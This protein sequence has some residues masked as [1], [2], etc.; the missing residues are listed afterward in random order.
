MSVK[1]VLTFK[2]DWMTFNILTETDFFRQI[3]NN[4]CNGLQTAYNGFI[5]QVIELCSHVAESPHSLIALL[6][7]ETELQHHQVSGD[8]AALVYVRKALT[9][10]EKIHKYLSTAPISAFPLSQPQVR[11]EIK[12]SVIYQWTR[13]QVELV[14]IIYGLAEMECFN[15]GEVQINELASYI[16]KLFGVEIKDCYH[17]YID[18]KRRKNDSRTY[19]LDK[20]RERLNLRMQRDDEK[21][22]KRIY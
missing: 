18:I 15:N 4:E 13:N 7:A 19:F 10:I 3:N 16:G 11:T 2:I 8:N 1:V 14:E 6:Y 22:R 20:L 5:A 9:F 17:T 21:K 12:P